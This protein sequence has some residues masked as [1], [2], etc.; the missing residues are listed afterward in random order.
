MPLVLHCP[1]TGAYMPIPFSVAM[2]KLLQPYLVHVAEARSKLDSKGASKPQSCCQASAARCK[3]LEHAWHQLTASAAARIQET[4]NNAILLS[5]KLLLL[6]N[7]Q[8]PC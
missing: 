4:L 2:P 5:P 3:T 7:E 8:L 6:Q 1:H